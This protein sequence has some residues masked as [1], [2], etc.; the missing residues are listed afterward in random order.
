MDRA[1]SLGYLRAC[2]RRYLILYFIFLIIYNFSVNVKIFNIGNESTW[3]NRILRIRVLSIGRILQIYF[4]CPGV[5]KCL[6][7]IKILIL[8]HVPVTM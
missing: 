3:L 6:K 8:L 1:Q 7:V 4:P 2:A 5:N